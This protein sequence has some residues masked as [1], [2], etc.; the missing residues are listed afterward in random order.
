MVGTHLPESSVS[1]I[2]NH[3]VEALNLLH[4]DP[5]PANGLELL[6][7]HLD[8]GWNPNQLHMNSSILNIVSDIPDAVKLLLEYGA[9]PNLG[10]VGAN[11]RALS[12]PN[13]AYP[14]MTAVRCG[15]VETVRLLL[16][17]GAKV[18][19]APVLYGALYRTPVED[20]QSECVE[21]LRLLLEH[22]GDKEVDKRQPYPNYDIPRFDTVL[23][24]AVY[25]GGG[26]LEEKVRLLVGAGARVDVEA[27]NEP[28]G[29][30]LV[31]Y[32]KTEMGE[33]SEVYKVLK[34]AEE[35]QKDD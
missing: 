2:P 8:T 16:A 22:G 15:K 34:E 21:I 4:R 24:A 26:K 9:D 23:Q 35:K 27:F 13:P 20:D 25:L 31:E 29:T 14:L 12:K 6:R 3:L 30:G 33:G 10:G 28:E 7:K 1:S 19:I 17:A 32:V 18:D 11:S 5:D